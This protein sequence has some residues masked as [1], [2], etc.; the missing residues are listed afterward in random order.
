MSTSAPPDEAADRVDQREGKK[1]EAYRKKMAADE[2]AVLTAIDAVA[3]MGR[4][5]TQTV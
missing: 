5:A 1:R 4:P 3:Y 2:A